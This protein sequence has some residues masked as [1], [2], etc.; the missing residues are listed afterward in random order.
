MP[1][2]H[3]ARG[4]E[5]ALFVH[6]LERLKGPAVEAAERS[7]QRGAEH[8]VEGPTPAVGPRR[9]QLNLRAVVIGTDDLHGK[10]ALILRR[11]SPPTSNNACVICP[12]E[13]TR[14]AS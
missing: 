9:V 3:P 1:F 2:F 14:T 8:G 10:P 7:R 11:Y 13:H 12:S 4:R 6:T 5:H